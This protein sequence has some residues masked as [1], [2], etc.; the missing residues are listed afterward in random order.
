MAAYL[1][2]YPYIW[3]LS[4]QKSIK[5]LTATRLICTIWKCL[6]EKIYKISSMLWLS[7][8]TVLLVLTPDTIGSDE[9]RR[10]I[11]MK[12]VNINF[13]IFFTCFATYFQ[14]LGMIGN[15][16]ES[17]SSSLKINGFCNSIHHNKLQV[18]IA[19]IILINWFYFINSRYATS[20]LI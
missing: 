15:V 19:F 13:F 18:H 17:F 4:P 10:K 1:K 7:S 5:N 8:C 6:A 16:F 12:Q 3:W 9:K 2:I 11:A 20:C 14:V